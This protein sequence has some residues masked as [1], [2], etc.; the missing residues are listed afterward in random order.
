[1]M[2]EFD[3]T[4]RS[5]FSN[6]PETLPE[7]LSETL[8]ETGKFKL[9]RIV[10]R[11]HATPEGEWYDQERH[12]WVVLLSGSAGLR[13]EGNDQLVTLSP[14]DHILLPAHSRHRVEW[15]DKHQDTVW[16][17]LHFEE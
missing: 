13:L 4:T 9:E 2:S 6:I 8:L 5:L 16:L 10:S 7:E 14:G 11:T 12:E 1:M 3:L 17:A 15:T